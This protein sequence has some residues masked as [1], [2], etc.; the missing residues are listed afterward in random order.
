M[1]RPIGERGQSEARPYSY[2]TNS[3]KRRDKCLPSE[4]IARL[5]R[6]AGWLGRRRT[7][8]P[9]AC[10]RCAVEGPHTHECFGLW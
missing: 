7:E 8:D 10:D 1:T 4:E 9:F 5:F 2:S 3:T 6:R